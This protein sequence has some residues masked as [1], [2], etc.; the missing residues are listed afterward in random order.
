MARIL[1]VDDNPDI[2]QI[3]AICLEDAGHQVLMASDGGRALEMMMSD[4]FEVVVLDIMMPVTDG[5]RVL[6]DMKTAGLREH[7]KVLFLTARNSEADWAQGF[8]LGADAYVTKPFDNDELVEAVEDLLVMS[9]TQL[10]SRRQ[11]ELD[12]AQLLSRLESVFDF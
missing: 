4:H 12:R 2:R 11:A 6:Q 3:V 10:S 1:V 9:K 5:Y 8:R 7:T